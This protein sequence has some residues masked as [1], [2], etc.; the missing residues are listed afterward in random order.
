MSNTSR[1]MQI[2]DV[3]K[4]IQSGYYTVGTKGSK[5]S[6]GE[7]ERRAISQKV[8][9]KFVGTYA[10]IQEEV[11][12]RIVEEKDKHLRHLYE[13]NEKEKQLM[14]EFKK[15]LIESHGLTTHPMADKC[16]ELA[17]YFT[18]YEGITILMHNFGRLAEMLSAK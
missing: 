4:R 14:L 15:D 12:R 11:D 8:R 13:V 6:F 9:E 10:Q 2:E 7:S 1:T 5:K 3:I 18:E 16:Y 17:E